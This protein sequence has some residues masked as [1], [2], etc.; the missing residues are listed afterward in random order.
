[1]RNWN[2]V[3]L[4]VFAAIALM[5]QACGEEGGE[6]DPE[7]SD[8]TNLLTNQIDEVIT[9]T[10][11]AYQ[12][13]LTN[14]NSTIQSVTSM[15]E[16]TLS[17]IRTAFSDAYIAYQS[18]AVHDYFSTSSIDLVDLT[19]LYPIDVTI[20]EDLIATESNRF[21][22]GDHERANGFP[23][24]DYML[25]GPSDVVSYFNEDQ[26]RLAFLKS[27][28]GDMKDRAD[29][30]TDQWSG[31]RE[32]FIEADG[33]SLGSA[34]SGQLNGSIAYYEFNVREN[35]VGIPIGRIGPNDSPITPDGTKI[36]AYYRSQFDGNDAFAIA[37]VRAAVEEMED[38]YLGTTSSGSDGQGYDELLNA[39]DQ[40]SLDTDIKAQFQLIINELNGRT[41]ITEDNNTDLYDAIQGLVT[42]FKSDMLPVLNVQDADGANDGD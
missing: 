27:L 23:A 40:S 36:E 41:S 24:L 39:R 3:Y 37:L 6:S 42:L 4:F 16:V 17:S 10:M 34:I 11:V 22:S 32:N 35:K 18:A 38:L 7:V 2:F 21:S 13:E 29:V 30:L 5:L 9:P 33:T 25:Y 8:F 26:K 1:M 31:L 14:F 28:V 19:N 12:T 20:L 15:D